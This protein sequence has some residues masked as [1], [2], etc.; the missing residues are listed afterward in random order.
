[1]QPITAGLKGC[2][3]DL[4]SSF[5]GIG[6]QVWFRD[7]KKMRNK[8]GIMIPN[9]IDPAFRLIDFMGYDRQKKN[10]FIHNLYS[11]GGQSDYSIIFTGH[12]PPSQILCNLGDRPW[13]FNPE[14]M[15]P[16]TATFAWWYLD[17]FC[18][19]MIHHSDLDKSWRRIDIDRSRF[20]RTSRR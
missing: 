10:Q 18:F 20:H 15:L 12:P 3:S 16:G 7:Q 14:I 8:T 11:S 5:K 2:F 13:V 17:R 4:G 19:R 1:M 9:A 6:V